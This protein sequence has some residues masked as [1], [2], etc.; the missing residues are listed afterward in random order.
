M[1]DL[2]I[3]TRIGVYAWEQRINQR[4]SFDLRIPIDLTYCDDNLDNTLD[5][6]KLCE[7]IT[8]FV[9]SNVFQLLETVASQVADMIQN[10]YAVKQ[11]SLSVTKIGAVPNAGGIR[12]Q[13][14]R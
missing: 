9:S 4:L 10:T 1:T 6:A 14:E 7:D 13:L 12:I 11:L 2:K 8:T 5:Y 3:A